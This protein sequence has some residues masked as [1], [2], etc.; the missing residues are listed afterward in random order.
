MML[1]RRTTTAT[2]RRRR[3]RAMAACEEEQ[4]DDGSPASMP[5]LEQLPPL[6]ASSS[7]PM[8]WMH[9][10]YLGIGDEVGQSRLADARSEEG[11]DE[12]G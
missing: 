2:T 10:H 6:M 4:G 11:T 9:P 12:G 1:Q 3:R 8:I 5:S 7:D